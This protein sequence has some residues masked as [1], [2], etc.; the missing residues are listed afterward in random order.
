MVQL[1]DVGTFM[2]SYES[3]TIS[4]PKHM[5]QWMDLKKLHNRSTLK[6]SWERWNSEKLN[7]GK[8]NNG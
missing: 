7:L 5:K 1:K 3:W 8:S 2:N 4:D 6:R